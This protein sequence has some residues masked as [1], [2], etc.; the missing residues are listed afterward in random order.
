MST[1]FENRR[2]VLF[3]VQGGDTVLAGLTM[4]TAEDKATW[5]PAMPV[6]IVRWGYIADTVMG[7]TVAV[8]ALD[9]RPTIGSDTDRVDGATNS[10]TFIDTAGGVLTS[11]VAT[12]VGA[13]EFHNVNPPL[14]VDPGE[15]VVF[16][17][18]TAP[19]SG[20]AFFFIEY[21]VQPFVGDSN[22]TAGDFSN[23]ISNMTER[24]T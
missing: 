11:G 17:M 15:E 1:G 12:A 7:N 19:S 16:Q 21:E 8:V 3:P 2:V 22:V 18:T 5:A 13:G 9:F 4:A 23:R 10:T 20:T 6:D 14:Q 24:T